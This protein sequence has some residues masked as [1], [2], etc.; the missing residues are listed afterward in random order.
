MGVWTLLR[1]VPR[2]DDEYRSPGEY[3]SDA[4]SFGDYAGEPGGLLRVDIPDPESGSGDGHA[5]TAI[6]NRSPQS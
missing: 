1:K 3:D 6:V 2:L 4:S 5:Q